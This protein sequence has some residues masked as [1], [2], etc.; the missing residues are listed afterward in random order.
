[1]TP[2]IYK[3][4]RCGFT[5]YPFFYSL[6]YF[7]IWQ[8]EM[9]N[10]KWKWQSPYRACLTNEQTLFLL[11]STGILDHSRFTGL[12]PYQFPAVKA[13]VSDEVKSR[14]PRPS[15]AGLW[16]WMKVCTAHCLCPASQRNLSPGIYRTCTNISLEWESWLNT[17][18]HPLKLFCIPNTLSN[19]LCHK[20]FM[21]LK[22]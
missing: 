9:E 4:L 16:G 13:T 8:Y 17:S 18:I 15:W 10:E 5:N 6:S 14:I 21:Q 22:T 19:K 2:N 3:N 12:P 11:Y 20:H 7:E 1:M